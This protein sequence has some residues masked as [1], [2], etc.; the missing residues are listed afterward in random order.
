[1]NPNM[2]V[3]PGMNIQQPSPQNQ[4]VPPPQM[5]QQQQQQQQLLNLDNISKVKNLLGPLRESLKVSDVLQLEDQHLIIHLPQ[6]VFNSAAQVLNQNNQIDVGCKKDD[7][8]SVRFD[9][10][11]EEFFAICDQIELNLV[12]AKKCMQQFNASQGYLP[13]PV[14]H[15]NESMANENSLTYNQ[16]LDLVRSQIT[17]AKEIH[18]TV[19]MATVN[20]LN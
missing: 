12:T 15:R 1:M 14:V 8:L 20:S 16:Y 7:S 5:Q 13:V 3:G 2:N 9:K 4:M 10:H 18:D 11:L 6:N 19:K 17:Y